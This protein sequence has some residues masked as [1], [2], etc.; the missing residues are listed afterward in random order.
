VPACCWAWPSARR[1]RPRC[2]GDQ[3]RAAVVDVG[4][5]EFGDHH[6]SGG[7]KPNDISLPGARV[8][9]LPPK[10]VGI[11]ERPTPGLKRDRSP[12]GMGAHISMAFP[13]HI[14]RFALE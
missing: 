1:W 11:D 8:Q 14:V 12:D 6:V 13:T 4:E 2:S 7:A 3:Q 9:C 10:Q 5:G